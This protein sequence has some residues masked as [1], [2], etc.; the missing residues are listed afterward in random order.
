MVDHL[1]IGDAV[2]WVSAFIFVTSKLSMSAKEAQQRW[3]EKVQ[4]RLRL[5]ST[6][7]GD[8]KSVKMLGLAQVMSTAV[9]GLRVAEIETSKVYRKLLVAMLLLCKFRGD[10]VP[11]QLASPT[12]RM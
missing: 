8:M 4:E 12:D 3:I 11:V 10:G 6:M 5:T 1:L 7:L 9:Q 2:R